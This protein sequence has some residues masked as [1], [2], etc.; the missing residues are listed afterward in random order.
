MPSLLYVDLNYLTNILASHLQPK[1]FFYFYL[2]LQ[3]SFFIF[4]FKK[5][6]FQH[7]GLSLRPLSMRVNIH[8]AYTHH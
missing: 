6:K 5:F 3:P 1:T 7:E 2:L 8:F 4:F